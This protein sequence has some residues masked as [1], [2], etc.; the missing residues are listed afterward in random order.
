M[1][2]VIVGAGNVATVFGRLMV[3]SGH[4]II[5]VVSRTIASAQSLAIELGCSFSDNLSALDQT[6]DIYILAITDQALQQIQGS[7]FLGD[8][9]IVHTAGSVSKQVLSTISTQFGVIYPLQSL[10]KE[11]IGGQPKIPLL[12]DANNPSVLS[13]IEKFAFSLSSIVSKV[14]DEQRFYLHLAAV[15]VNNFTNHL[16][17]LTAEYCKNEGVDFKMLQPIIEETALRLKTRLPSDVQTG[18]AIRE[19]RSTLER[20]LLALSNHPELK[21]MYQTFTESLLKIRNR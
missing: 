21:I 11:Q 1:R 6:A 19:D 16:Y 17:S 5:Q 12:I 4:V 2:V 9:L 15:I 10:R 8:K 13:V 14:E 18:P 20:H 7:I 3:S